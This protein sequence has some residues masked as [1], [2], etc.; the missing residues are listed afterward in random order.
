MLKLKN[1]G[2][3]GYDDYYKYE[4]NSSASMAIY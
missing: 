2:F 4:N 3:G 1:F